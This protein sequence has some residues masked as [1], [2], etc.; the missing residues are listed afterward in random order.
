VPRYAKFG[1]L[2]ILKTLG[3]CDEPHLIDVGFLFS[4]YDMLKVMRFAWMG[5][6]I[7][8]LRFMWLHA[9]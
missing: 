5:K 9:P 4:S 8:T 6:A 3:N 1:D 7:N 2:F